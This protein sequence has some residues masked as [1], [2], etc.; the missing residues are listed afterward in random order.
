MLL[1]LGFSPSS[2]S[3]VSGRYSGQTDNR[4]ERLE[5]LSMYIYT[6]TI[7]K[8]TQMH[9]V[10]SHAAL[11]TLLECAR[12]F[13]VSRIVPQ[14]ASLKSSNVHSEEGFQLAVWL[15]GVERPGWP[16][17]YLSKLRQKV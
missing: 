13:L 4:T 15:S 11:S 7:P 12:R 17:P 5:R 14:V 3:L 1:V 8:E 9:N 10:P 16:D 6:N 2:L